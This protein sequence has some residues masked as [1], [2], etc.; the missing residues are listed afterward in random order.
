MNILFVLTDE[1]YNELNFALMS[2]KTKQQYLVQQD[3]DP[4]VTGMA[5][6]SIVE[7]DKALALL[8]K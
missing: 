2:L 1:E 5:T 3:V 7:I 6:N 4:V 8:K